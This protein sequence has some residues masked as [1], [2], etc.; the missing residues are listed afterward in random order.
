MATLSTAIARYDKPY[1]G[2]Y[3]PKE[4]GHYSLGSEIQYN[5]TQ[6]KYFIPPSDYNDVEYDLKK[7]Y[8][9]MENREEK[10]IDHILKW[11]HDSVGPRGEVD[12]DQTGLKDDS[13]VSTDFVCRRGLLK[14]LLCTTCARNDYWKF[15]V[16]L[17]HGTY[18]LCEYPTDKEL[19]RV[20]KMTN[21]DKMTC[22]WGHKFEQYLTAD[23]KGSVPN[24]DL[25]Y[26]I[27]EGFYTVMESK[28]GAH[29]LVFSSEVD[30]VSLE[31]PDGTTGPS[32]EHYV[33]F[34]TTTH[35]S[36]EK[37]SFKRFKLLNW[38]SQSVLAGVPEIIC[39]FRDDAGLVRKLETYTTQDIPTIAGDIENPWKIN[40]CWNFLDHLLTF[41]KSNVKEDDP[42][43]IHLLE[44]LGGDVTCTRLPPD[45][46]YTFLHE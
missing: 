37:V 9:G 15:A 29:T 23:S 32:V 45:S 22:A 28:V 1:Q 41:I 5:K 44:F 21:E 40:V 25:P 39:G 11:I 18:Y 17:H 19:K 6:L 38:W 12:P 13:D 34:K 8:Q 16:T 26:N 24:P 31:I 33:E 35:A 46:K 7:E 14:K 42:R 30:A 10:Q 27:N 3:Q 2:L 20:K 43:I 36:L 4:I